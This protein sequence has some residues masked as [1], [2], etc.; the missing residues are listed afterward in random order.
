MLAASLVL[1]FLVACSPD[2]DTGSAG[3]AETTAAADAQP[4]VYEAHDFAPPFTVEPPSWLPPEPSAAE[5]HFLTWTGEG[6]DVDRA[7]RF[8]SPIGLY[9]PGHRPRHLSPLPENYV[10]YLLGLSRFGAEISSPTELDVD[11]HSATVVTAGTTT[12]LS[13]SLGCPAPDL[14][15]DDCFGLQE[16]AVLRLAAIDVDGTI[17]VAWARTVPGS[18]QSEQDFAAFEDLLRTVRFD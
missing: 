8:L 11:G 9:D 13:G 16:F 5:Q 2:G 14:V 12:G 7:V 15:A 17:L 18:P 1:A 3:D 10:E 4:A 6:A